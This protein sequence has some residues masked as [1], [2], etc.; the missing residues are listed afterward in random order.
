[1][2]STAGGLIFRGRDSSGGIYGLPNNVAFATL[3]NRVI[4]SQNSNSYN[5]GDSVAAYIQ[6]EVHV[7]P[8]LDLVGG[9]RET[10]DWKSGNVNITVPA[11]KPAPPSSFTYQANKPTYLIGANYKLVEDTMVYVKYST[12]FVSGGSVAGIPFVP[13]TVESWEA[14]LKG[15]YFDR[16]LRTN[17][18]VYDADYYHVQIAQGGSTY[19]GS[20]DQTYPFLP[21]IGTFIIDQGGVAHGRGVEFEGTAIV[22]HGASLG[23]NMSYT[24]SYYDNVNSAADSPAT[25]P[26]VPTYLPR[27]TIGLWGEY[28]HNFDNGWKG[29]VR[30]DGDWRSALPVASPNLATVPTSNSATNPDAVYAGLA[31]VPPTWLVNGRV[32]LSGL[33]FGGAAGEV[34]LWV[35]NLTDDRSILYDQV[36]PNLVASAN[37]QPARTFALDVN[38]KY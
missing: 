19:S 1:M 38:F 29:M 5:L 28:D 27:W 4:P 22:A 34:A 35:K 25:I 14:G 37:F 13:E 9:M 8:K 6:A 12:A 16:H 3:P 36:I 33:K 10:K 20:L 26:P 31:S 23:A 15:E 24:D 18:A 30:M 17:I 21:L 7:T 2:T 32:A 11:G